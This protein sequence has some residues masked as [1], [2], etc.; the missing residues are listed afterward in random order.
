MNTDMKATWRKMV[1]TTLLWVALAALVYTPSSGGGTRGV[2]VACL[3][4]I[5]F[6]AGLALFAD[7]LK[8][9]IVEQIRRKQS[10]R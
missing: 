7:G 1:G 4:F 8:R 10:E 5:S 6:A 9:D 3:G 2:I